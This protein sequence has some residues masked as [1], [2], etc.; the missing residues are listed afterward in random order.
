[1]EK[2]FSV[3][4]GFFGIWVGVTGV[5]A[6]VLPLMGATLQQADNRQP[7]KKQKT[8]NPPRS[9]KQTT[10]QEAENRQPSKKQKTD[11]PPRSKTL[12]TL[13]EAEN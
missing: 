12:T 2:S 13:Q 1:M 6:G 7:F 11:N 10:L 3:V 4:F 5:K 8:G 9:R